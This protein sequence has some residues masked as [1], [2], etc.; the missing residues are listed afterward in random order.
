MHVKFAKIFKRGPDLFQFR[1]LP[2]QKFICTT[3]EAPGE[4]AAAA[5]AAAVRTAFKYKLVEQNLEWVPAV[6]D[7]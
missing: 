3:V 2:C 5:A 6:V 1:I 7:L 4:T